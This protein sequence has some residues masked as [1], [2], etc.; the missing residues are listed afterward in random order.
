VQAAPQTGL[1]AVLGS[2]TPAAAAPRLPNTA[3][4][5]GSAGAVQVLP[6]LGIAALRLCRRRQGLSRSVAGD[7]RPAAAA[8]APLPG[9]AARQ[10]AVA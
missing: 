4:G 5:I 8:P 9:K 2:A 10:R 7:R 1:A 6:L 3:S